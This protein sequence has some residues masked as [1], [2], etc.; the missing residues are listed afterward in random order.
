MEDDNNF[1]YFNNDV[2]G[3]SENKLAFL[4]TEVK[5]DKNNFNNENEIK[6]GSYT[7]YNQNE[8]FQKYSCTKILDIKSN[9][10]TN[11]Y[12]EISVDSLDLFYNKIKTSKL[13]LNFL[14]PME[15]KEIKKS[16]IMNIFKPYI[17]N[18]NYNL[19]DY[20]IYL[21]VLNL[22]DDNYC[23]GVFEIYGFE[24][25]NEKLQLRLSYL[26]QS[27]SE[28]TIIDTNSLKTIPI[29]N[30]TGYKVFK[31]INDLN[32][33]DLFENE[34][35]EKVDI[36]P[37]IIVLNESST[38]KIDFTNLSNLTNKDN[39]SNRRILEEYNFVSINENKEMFLKNQIFSKNQISLFCDFLTN[40]YNNEYISL[41]LQIYGIDIKGCHV[42]GIIQSK[43]F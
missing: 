31:E 11:Y 24:K 29:E 6:N 17:D 28:Y 15:N 19:I 8:N 42:F 37:D 40:I 1:F 22:K 30:I 35:K 41:Y 16:Y 14:Y 5:Q 38:I 7:N 21:H 13:F 18:E 4:T 36:L 2:E 12:L 39:V 33:D 9:D 27:L 10:E 34:F 26:L 32:N 43:F 25:L 20:G 23:F 3:D